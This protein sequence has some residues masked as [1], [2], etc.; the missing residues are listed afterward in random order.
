MLKAGLVAGWRFQEPTGQRQ[1]I[2]GTT[3]LDEFGGAILSAESK[4]GRAVSLLSGLT[5][6]SNSSPVVSGSL[7]M[8]CWV[9]HTTGGGTTSI[10]MSLADTGSL[11]LISLSITGAASAKAPR[12]VHQ[13]VGTFNEGTRVSGAGWTHIALTCDEQ[14][15]STYQNGVRVGIHA[16]SVDYTSINSVL[17]GTTAVA[18]VDEAY[19][20]NRVL[21]EA[22][23]ARLY[24][25]N[26][27]GIS[28]PFTDGYSFM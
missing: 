25:I 9:N 3:P 17:F 5:L 18:L 2:L 1:D 8:S 12:Y 16:G 27:S 19:I 20:W 7:T 24:A 28:Y 22:E 13:G 26:N 10:I 14:A 23:V 21:N 6:V 11:A 4:F 15:M